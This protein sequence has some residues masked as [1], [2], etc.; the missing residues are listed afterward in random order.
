MA[1][2]ST[3]PV[4]AAPGASGDD[5]VTL[6]GDRVEYNTETRIG[7]AD[8]H[9]RATGR[10]VVITADHLEANLETQD[11]MATGNATLTRGDN[12]ASGSFLRYNLRTREG[13]VEQMKGE[14][15]PWHLTADVIDLGP[16]ADVAHAASVTSCDPAHP[17]YLVTAKK[18]EIVPNDHFTAYDASLWVAG[19][20]VITLPVYTSVVGHSSGPVLGINTPDG[21]YLEYK[22]SFYAGEL[23]D[24]YR[25]R[26]GAS[27][28]LA[29]ENVL[30]EKF[31]DHTLALHLGRFQPY[32]PGGNLVNVDRYSVDVEYD[33]IKI[34][35]T[36]LDF[37]VE[38][39]AGSYS[40]VATA[41]TTTRV[42]GILDLSTETFRLSPTL[43]LSL[44]GQV[45][46]DAYGTGQQ[47][48][49]LGAAAAFSTS[50]GDRGTA[51]LSYGFNAI[52]GTSPFSFDHLD[53]SS[54]ITLNYTYSFAAGFLETV[55]SFLNYDFLQRQYVFNLSVAMRVT[56]DTLVNITAWY[57]LTTQQLTEVDY[58]INQR[59]DCIAIGLL[60]RTFPQSASGNSLMVTLNINAFPGRSF[61]FSGT[62]VNYSAP[63]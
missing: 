14:S 10:G 9:A 59:C 1:T 55:N 58:A 38:A 32:D 46:Y 51:V 36:P 35:D 49:Q 57:N 44:S 18:I 27:S 40:E 25:V 13:R 62:G 39:H 43:N 47:R 52:N 34:R 15:P 30:S 3:I 19:T 26:Y 45:R 56:A 11:V 60:Y 33:R 48:T 16:R 37:Q 42:E 5:K 24:E 21:V 28:G 63:P 23:L 53:P 22:N 20:R 31:R 61:S 41:V 17:I 8:G 54:S 6:S 4:L 7:R 2:L 50:V 29:A 12:T